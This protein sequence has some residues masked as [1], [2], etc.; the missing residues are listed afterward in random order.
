MDNGQ[1]ETAKHGLDEQIYR[2]LV[3]A[4]KEIWNRK[5]DYRARDREKLGRWRLTQWCW[6]QWYGGVAEDLVLTRG[7]AQCVE[8]GDYADV[9]NPEGANAAGRARFR[10][11]GRPR[12]RNCETY[13][14]RALR[15]EATDFTATR[16]I[17]FARFVAVVA[18]LE[19]VILTGQRYC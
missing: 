14:V 4:E 12:S 8:I 16:S 13:R 9:E 5:A 2:A 11:I 18:L 19:I 7:Q 1:N 17:H 6:R 10:I 15:I 3:K